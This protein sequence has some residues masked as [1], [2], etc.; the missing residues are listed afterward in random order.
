MSCVSFW[1]RAA[2]V[3]V[4]AGITSTSSS[5]SLSG[6]QREVDVNSCQAVLKFLRVYLLNR[7]H[8]QNSAPRP[9][10]VWSES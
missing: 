4:A 9:G 8:S 7:L 2:A 5:S 6:I 10:Q 1:S 3:M